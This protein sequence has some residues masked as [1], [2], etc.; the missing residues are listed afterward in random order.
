MKISIKFIQTG[1]RLARP[2]YGRNGEMLLNSGVILTEQYIK[3]L[4][5]HGVLTVDIDSGVEEDFSDVL[6]DVVR[7]QVMKMVQQEI[8][9]EKNQINIKN[10]KKQVELLIDE[11]ISGKKV[12]GNLTE[13]CSADMY[14]FAHSVDVCTLSLELGIKLNY[15]KD[16]LLRLGVGCLLHDLGKTKILPAILNKPG[17]LDHAELIEIRKHPLYGYK[18]LMENEEDI[19]PESANI[20]LDHHEKYDGSGYPRGL[21]GKE[22]DEMCVICSVTDVYNAITTD[23][24]YRKSIPPH[25]AYEM[26]MASSSMMFEPKVVDTFLK[27]IVP[28]SVGSV[29]RLSNGLMGRVFRLNSNLPLRPVIKV[30]NSDEEI[31]LLEETS[32]VITGIME[33]EDIIKENQG[34]LL[35]KP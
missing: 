10:I 7:C 6:E 9:G 27:C 30:L 19:E 28:Y 26:I 3:S 29:V 34:L 2:L 13:I 18:M 22:I 20:V 33:P 31:N 15:K 24:V 17:K 32:I 14:T 25:E 16:R 8:V 35:Q 21:K 23:R 1:M 12:I 5:R 4:W 11:I